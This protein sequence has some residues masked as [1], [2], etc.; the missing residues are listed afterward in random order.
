MELCSTKNLPNGVFIQPL[1]IAAVCST[2]CERIQGAAIS[3]TLG[4]EPDL[5]I[6]L[7][8]YRKSKCYEHIAGK[9]CCLSKICE[10]AV[11]LSIQRPFA[12]SVLL[13]KMSFTNSISQLS[14]DT[15]L[16]G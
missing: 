2:C 11:G 5:E 13:G 15:D 4:S 7:A 14:P 3:K 12:M 8:L 10:E 9:A 16:V 6:E 1:R